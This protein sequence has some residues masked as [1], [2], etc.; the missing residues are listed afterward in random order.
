MIINKVNFTNPSALYS[1]RIDTVPYSPET[2]DR[3]LRRDPA[4]MGCVLLP[5]AA[6][7]YDI[8]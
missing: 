7:L 2:F 8:T 6:C 5:E 3:V 4:I 1:D